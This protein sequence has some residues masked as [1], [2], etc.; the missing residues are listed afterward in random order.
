MLKCVD[1]AADEEYLTYET[2]TGDFEWQAH[3]LVDAR[4]HFG[5]IV[6]TVP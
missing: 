5:K 3:R 6:L 4:T 1:A 2:T